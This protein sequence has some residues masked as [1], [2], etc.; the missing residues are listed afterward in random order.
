MK[1]S[2]KLRDVWDIDRSKKK[3]RGN[4]RGLGG[5]SGTF[6]MIT[7]HGLLFSGGGRGI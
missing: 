3:V 7:Y 1:L 4:Q 2:E 5:N 6:D